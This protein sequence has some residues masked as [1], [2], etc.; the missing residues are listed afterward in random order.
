[1][2]I[3]LFYNLALLHVFFHNALFSSR[4][5]LSLLNLMAKLKL[6]LPYKPDSFSNL[7]HNGCF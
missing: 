6:L 5:D 3:N 7:L 2:P 4:L 1:M